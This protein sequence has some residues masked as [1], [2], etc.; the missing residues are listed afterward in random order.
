MEGYNH[1]VYPSM[2][3]AMDLAMGRILKELTRLGVANETFVVFTSDNG[4]YGGV[5]DARP[6]RAD[7]GHLYEGGIRVPL[8]VRWPGKVKAGSRSA[9]PVILTDFYPTLLRVAGLEP[10]KGYPSDGENLLPLL[11]GT[12]K[13]KRDAL[14]WHFPNFAFHK[15]TR[16][17]S[18]IRMG[19]HK[20]IHFFDE[21]EVELYNLRT[22]LSETRNLA[23]EDPA[24]ADRMRARLD[25]W[26]KKSE[27]KLPRP[28]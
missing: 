9:E 13:F 1:K 23:A 10:Q 16:L 2:I 3:E 22:D 24:L 12:E 25:A 19:D 17:G 15:E 28:R 11:A 14:F 27:A 8:I 18:A 26:R 4:P 20:L 5:G 6:L 21:N 7:K